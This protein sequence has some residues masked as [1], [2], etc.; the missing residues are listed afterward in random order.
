M[1]PVTILEVRRQKYQDG[2]GEIQVVC[3]AGDTINVGR[4]LAHV[5]GHNVGLHDLEV[6]TIIGDAVRDFLL[7]PV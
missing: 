4:V 2:G 1:N 7:S 3:R 5:S 6:A